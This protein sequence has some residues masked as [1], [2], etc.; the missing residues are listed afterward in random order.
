MGALFGFFPADC[1]RRVLDA[2]ARGAAGPRPGAAVAGGDVFDEDEAPADR[3]AGGRRGD[4][5][6]QEAEG[7]VGVRA[8]PGPLHRHVE[9]GP[10]L[11]LRPGVP[12]SHL[13]AR[14]RTEGPVGRTASGEAGVPPGL[15][16]DP[17]PQAAD[18]VGRRIDLPPPLQRPPSAHR[19]PMALE[20][21]VVRRLVLRRLHL[22]LLRPRR[23]PHQQAR[24]RQHRRQLTATRPAL[25]LLARPPHP[26]AQRTPARLLPT[27]RRGIRRLCR[28]RRRRTTRG[29]RRRP[30]FVGRP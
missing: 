12:G 2:G 26:H 17:R 15:R 30:R 5:R 9:W 11:P 7:C 6:A 19:G 23:R 24:R 22:S 8:E 3:G 29:R 1:R 28:Q 25:Q 20:M 14:H 27:R 21:V 16:D 18:G 10:A 13:H 4:F